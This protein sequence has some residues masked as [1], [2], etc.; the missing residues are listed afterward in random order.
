M[1]INQR[2]PLVVCLALFVVLIACQVKI[3]HSPTSTVEIEPRSAPALRPVAT[4]ISPKDGMVAVYVPAGEFRM[5]STDEEIDDIYNECYDDIEMPCQREWFESEMPA[6]NVYLDDFWI[7]QTEVTNKKYQMCMEEGGCMPLM[8]NESYTRDSYFGNS[9]Y[10]NFPVVYVDWH[11]AS[12]YCEWA[13]RRLPT[14]AEWEKA[15]RGTDGRVYPWGKKLPSGG[16][17]NF[18]SI[19]NDTTEVGSY[20][21][22][23]SPYGA[24]DMAGNVQEW[25]ADWYD[26]GYYSISPVE[27]PQGP[28]SGEYRA[29]RGCGWGDSVDFTLRSTSRGGDKPVLPS[30]RFYLGFRCAASDT[31]QMSTASQTQ[32]DVITQETTVP[33]D[34]LSGMVVPDFQNMT[35]KLPTGTTFNGVWVHPDGTPWIY[36]DTGIYSIDKNGQIN[37]LFDRPVSE[38]QGVDKSGR[39]WVLGERYDFIAAFDGQDWKVYGPDQGWDALPDHPYLSPGIGN[40]LTHDPQDRIWIATGADL[41][42]LYEPKTDAWRSLSSAQLGFPPYQN[43]DYQGYFLT[44]TLVSETGE[45]WLSAC[46]GE[47]ETLRPFGIWR[48][49]GSRWQEIEAANQDCVLDMAAGSDGVIWAAGFDGLLKY[50]PQ[51]DTWTRVALP[52]FERRQVISRITINPATGL[53]WIQVVHYGGASLYGSLAYYHLDASGWVLDLESPS[54]SETGMAFEPDGIAWMCVDGQVLKYDG[55]DFTEMAE[56]NLKDCRITIDGTGRVWVVG[57]DQ[58]DIWMLNLG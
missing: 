57:V 25:T 1:N 46:I 35:G 40:D 11:M 3:T 42:R 23:A 44:D 30:L 9:I 38:V 22:G 50:I 10:D 43:A 12:A 47:G 53:P 7:D 24:L 33:A 27:N 17:L 54:F 13:G 31:L 6:H 8:S 39:V 41:V 4:Q 18:S 36:G 51:S 45:V 29:I 16:L 32:S 28:S 37:L 26:K 15:A 21:A 52:P 14:E 34:Q 5:G 56:L 48:Y 19:R 49:A 55:N 20:P 58:A 2:K